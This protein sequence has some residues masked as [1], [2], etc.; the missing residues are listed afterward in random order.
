M[1][2]CVYFG[3]LLNILR[4]G[5]VVRV[6]LINGPVFMIHCLAGVDVAVDGLDVVGVVA[7]NGQ[8]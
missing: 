5:F 1:C 2:W 8:G 3:W 6:L 7:S 4:W